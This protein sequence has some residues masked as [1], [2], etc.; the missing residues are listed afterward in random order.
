MATI[1]TRK[2][3]HIDIVLKKN[4]SHGKKTSGLED[5]TVKGFEDVELNYSTLPEMDLDEVN[6]STTFLKKKFSAPVFVSGMVGGIERAKGINKRV[7]RALQNLE[8]GMGVGSQRAMIKNPKTRNTYDVR[9]VAP[10]IFVSGNV[11]VAQLKEY[12]IDV[13]E[14]MVADI[15]AD[16]LAIHVNAAQEAVQPEGD[17]DFSGL[18]K[19]IN[20]VS[21]KLSK[22]VYVKEVGH[23]FSLD[24]AKKLAKT[25]IKAIDV[26]G[27]GGTSWTAIEGF[28]GNPEIA[29]TYWN[30]GIPTAVS[31]YA[32]RKAFKGQ[33][34]ASGGIRNGLDI[35]KGIILGADLGGLASPIIKADARGGTTAVEKELEKIIHE[36]KIGC[37]LLGCKNI[38]QLKKKKP[39]I[40]GKTRDWI[41]QV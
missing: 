31:V 9:D 3:D 40:V 18:I 5:V 23:G 35:V 1:G 8:L 6:L 13:L 24:V 37:Y 14:N 33:I 15:G 26:Q 39:V 7:A 25:S 21:K 12:D 22:P 29:K 27:V 17:V 41:E 20:R 30:F 16:A 11:G 2:K 28:R 38:K 34:I 4:V 19:E 36:I 10:D 32:C